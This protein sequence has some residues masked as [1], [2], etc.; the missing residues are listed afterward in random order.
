MKAIVWTKYG[1][2]DVLQLKEVGKPTPRNNQVLIR[3]HAT[4]VETGDCEIRRFK[5]H[6]WLWFPLRIYFGLI[7]PRI[8]PGK[9]L[10]S[11]AIPLRF[12][13]TAELDR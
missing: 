9:A 6:N 2:P 5:I 1:P 3:I 10:H 7:R 8:K 4:T 11:S 12:R 13:A